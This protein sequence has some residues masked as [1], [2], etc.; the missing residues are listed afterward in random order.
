[1]LNLGSFQEKMRFVST[2]FESGIQ[3]S[4]YIVLFLFLIVNQ[5]CQYNVN[6][7]VAPSNLISQE[8]FIGLLVD[9]SMAEAAANSN[10]KKVPNSQIDSVYAFDLLK[11]RRIR[12]TQYDSTLFYYSNHIEEY[13]IIYEKVIETLSASQVKRKRSIMDSSIQ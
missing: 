13:K 9:F 6:R 5:S 10:V 1:M 8:R 3:K 11:E 7:D 12:K 4:F 2:S